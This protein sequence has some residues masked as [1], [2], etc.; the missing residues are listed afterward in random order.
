MFTRHA[1]KRLKQRFDKLT[2]DGFNNLTKAI[3]KE[4]SNKEFIICDYDGLWTIEV[5]VKYKKHSMHIKNLAKLKAMC[6]VDFK[7]NNSFSIVTIYKDDKLK[8]YER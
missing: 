1:I 2:P 5:N 8:S 6:V 7:D 4:I 3:E